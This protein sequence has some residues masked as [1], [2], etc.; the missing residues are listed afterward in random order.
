MLRHTI[1]ALFRAPVFALAAVA[2]LAIAIGATTAIFSVVDGVLL[3]PL[4]F[5]QS[6]RLVAVRHVFPT[7]DDDEH[8]ASPAF[9]FTYRDNNTTFE[10][11]ALWFSNTATVTGGGDPEEIQAVR[12]SVEF[13]PTLRVEP[14]LGRRFTS[15]DDTPGSPP[16]AMLSYAYWQRRFGG[17]RDVIG[18]TLTLDGAPVEIVGVL[19]ASFRFLE[20]QAEVLTPAQAVRAQSFAG[21]IGERVI[22]RLKDG[23]T[24]EQASADVARMIPIYYEASPRAPWL[25]PGALDGSR[26]RPSL[27]LLKD[28]VVGD[29]DEALLVLMSTI[30]MLL[31]IACANIA[32]LLLVRTESR[33]SE[34]AI[35]AALG[36]SSSAI[37]RSLLLESAV[38][39]LAG[40][41]AGLLLASLGLPVLLRLAGSALPSA[42]DIG[43]GPNV[44][45]FA[46]GVSLLCGALLCLLPIAK[47]AAPR[48][49]DALR[50]AARAYSAGRESHRARNTLVV[51]QVALALVLL[52]A[53]GL[54]IRSFVAL[55]SVDPG[56]QDPRAVQTFRI[57]VP[58]TDF[59][60]VVRTQ[61]DIAD[62]IAALPGVESVAYA[63][64]RP[65]L[66][67]GPSGPFLFGDS[68][69]P[70]ETEFRYASPGFF[71]TLGTP[72]LAGRDFEWTDIYE[73]RQVAIVSANIA[74]A[75]WGSPAAALGKELRRVANAPP[76]TIVGVVGDIRHY[77]VDRRAPEAVYL[78]QAEFVAQYATRIMFYF[79]RSERVGDPGFVEEL[80]RAV[81][82]VSPE[83]PLGSVEPLG[84]VYDRSMARTS[85]TLVL[86]AITSGMALLLGL[87]GIYAVIAYVLAQ[88]T[89]ELGIRMALG[90]RAGALK[91]MLV[92]HVLALV[93]IGVVLGAGAAA[94]LSRLMESLL[95]GVTALDPTT[96]VA[97]SGTLFAVALLAGYLPARRVTRIDPMQSLRA[98]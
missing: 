13:L 44:A 82:A 50:G 15:A 18:R 3:E 83:L 84:A 76:T 91:G 7:L 25:P 55:R 19:P 14:L 23:A 17:E 4:P 53:S 85:L 39:A 58:S 80:Q 52:I 72:L 9:Y 46:F 87:V 38:L 29:L 90:A 78:T 79:V 32:N 47:H 94:A 30:G 86:L 61:N 69:D 62:R 75:R 93:A 21:P 89:R 51:T 10:S 41:A 97:V 54:M 5:P 26:T 8:D 36:A 2:T 22:A 48:V 6:D 28:R 40:G 45:A 67:Q 24:L 31:L 59:A 74:N 70:A 73:K 68:T 16:T 88:R 96:Y 92:R 37:A 95:F 64:R 33:R 35:R 98:E 77:G 66:G 56:V 43:I 42:L 20:D 81:W 63:S 65:L 49:I 60:R 11:V 12:A 71:A 27:R 1:R 34:L 57:S